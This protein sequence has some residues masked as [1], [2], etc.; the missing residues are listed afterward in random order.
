MCM[1]SSKNIKIYNVHIVIHTLVR[2][3]LDIIHNKLKVFFCT[4]QFVFTLSYL[5]LFGG[6]FWE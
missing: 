4:P 5:H 6:W 1:F 3:Y 2:I